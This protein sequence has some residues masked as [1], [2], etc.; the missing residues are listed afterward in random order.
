[1]EREPVRMSEE[2]KAA[3]T[4]TWYPDGGACWQCSGCERLI[5][6]AFDYCTDGH[7]LVRRPPFA[8]AL[9]AAVAEARA[10]AYEDAASVAEIEAQKEPHSIGWHTATAI[11]RA[12]RSRSPEVTPRTP[13]RGR[14]MHKGRISPRLEQF[15]QDQRR[16]RD[17]ND[18]P[19]APAAETQPLE[20][21]ALDENE[22]VTREDDLAF[23][24][25]VQACDRKY[26]AD[27]AAGTKAWF[28]D[29]LVPA[30]AERGFRI[31]RAQPSPD[32]GRE[33]LEEVLRLVSEGWNLSWDAG[34]ALR[35]SPRDHFDN[36]LHYARERRAALRSQDAAP[37]V[38]L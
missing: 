11:A 13:D 21:P 14:D 26:Q 34:G 20:Y 7:P 2:W 38:S 28:R 25:A 17:M 30:L 27:G 10:E 15:I 3:P 35:T 18:T 1:M 8:D 16:G 9:A 22:V 4:G 33:A 31:T 6:N 37:E 29:Y 36:A 24:L 19:A 32:T 23:R 12:I 5:G